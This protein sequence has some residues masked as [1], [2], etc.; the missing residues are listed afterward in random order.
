MVLSV[1][2]QQDKSS[3][4]QT[5]I[6]KILFKHQN[7][8]FYSK[9]DWIEEQVFQS[10]RSIKNLTLHD[11]EQPALVDPTRVTAVG[12]DYPVTFQPLLFCGFVKQYL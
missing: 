7:K 5:E 9:H 10:C 6:Q 2:Q 4:A 8:L 11:P 12:T 1:S 3:W